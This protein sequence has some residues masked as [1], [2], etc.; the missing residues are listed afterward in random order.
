MTPRAG[1]VLRA[2]APPGALDARRVREFGGRPRRHGAAGGA[3]PWLG[4]A[5]AHA[6]IAAVAFFVTWTVVV[7]SIEEEPPVVT[8]MDFYAP[9]FEPVE[10]SL[11]DS[12]EAPAASEA[13]APVQEAPRAIPASVV[14]SLDRRAAVVPGDARSNAIA[15][16]AVD[17]A[18]RTATFAG[19]QASNAKRIVYVVGASGA[20]TGTFPEIAHELAKSLAKLDHRQSFAVIFFQKNEALIVPPGHLMPATSENVERAIEWFERRVFPTGRGNPLAALEAAMALKPD[21]IFLLSAG[22]SG[23]GEYEIDDD[24]LVDAID[25]L[26]PVVSRSGRRRTRIQCVAFFD[27]DSV[28]VLERIAERHGGPGSFRFL[29]RD[30]LGLTPGQR[31]PDGAP[32]VE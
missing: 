25:D 12:I 20:L 13:L 6:L 21:L 24:A 15:P 27:R 22:V 11:A 4:S 3:L 16:L 5:L 28:A 26:N 10:P 17:G 2:D 14:A 30:E 7:H 23:A 9:V 19:L 31:G 18:G 1:S 8:L 32:I 29:S